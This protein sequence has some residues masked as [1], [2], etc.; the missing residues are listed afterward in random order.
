MMTTHDSPHVACPHCRTLNRIPFARLTDDPVC[1]KCGQPLLAG[2][3]ITL[4]DATFD[5]V[6]SRTDL[7][8]VVD[9]WASWCGPC[10]MMAPQFAE[11]ARQLKGKVVLAK[12]DSD[13]SPRTAARFGIRSIPT[14]V[15]LDHGR[16]TRR[17]SGAVQ[18]SQIVSFSTE[19]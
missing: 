12:V 1:G 19:G 16:E 2:Q 11:A 10:Q 7:P 13:A 6:T 15:R 3:P 18:A 17:Q 8:V 14:M 4:D 5:A 9:F